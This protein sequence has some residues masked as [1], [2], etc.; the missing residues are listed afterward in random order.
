[1]FPIYKKATVRELKYF[2][3]VSHHRFLIK[4]LQ[5]YNNFTGGLLAKQG[6][7]FTND[8]VF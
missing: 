7:P 6:K 1:M 8:M 5:D 2:K 4:I 3:W